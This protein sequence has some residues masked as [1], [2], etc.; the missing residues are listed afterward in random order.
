M[1][2]FFAAAAAIALSFTAIAPAG[3]DTNT[4]TTMQAISYADLDLNDRADARTMLRRINHAARDMCG[5]RMGNM[6]VSERYGVRACMRE[7]TREAVA[8][9]DHPMLTAVY[10]RRPAP[11][12]MMLAQR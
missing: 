6:S 5:D 3:A 10:E 8:E 11:T 9:L 2:T 4:I 12:T 1:K 7:A